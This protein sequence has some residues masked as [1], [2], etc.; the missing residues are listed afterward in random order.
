LKWIGCLLLFSGWIIVATALLLL[1]GLAQR[2]SF[3]T[4]GLLVELLGLALLALSYKAP[5]T[6]RQRGQP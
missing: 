4:A 2:F 6:G 1:T 3:I 5:Q